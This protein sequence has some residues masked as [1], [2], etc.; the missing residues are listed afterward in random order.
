MT[1]E[2]PDTANTTEIYIA[3]K[4]ALEELAI[5]LAEGEHDLGADATTAG[6]A[7]VGWTGVDCPWFVPGPSAGGFEVADFTITEEV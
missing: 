5:A 3:T 4:D 2:S 1:H 6:G 7:L